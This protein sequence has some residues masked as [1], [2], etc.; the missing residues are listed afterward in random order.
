MQSEALRPGL[1][2][3]VR[4]RQYL[5]ER[6]TRPSPGDAQRVDLVCLDDDAQGRPLSVLWDLE[7]GAQVIQ[8]ES[9]GLGVVER[10]DE[11]RAFAAYLHALKWNC[12]TATDA[13]L[14]QAP[15]RAGI[16]LFNHQ[17]TPLQKALALPR[18]NLFIADDVGLG[19]TIEAGLVLQEL[20]LRQRAKT[21]LIVCP[22]SVVLQW[23]VEMERRFGIH[24]EIF[25][26]EF[27]ARR[28]QERG[29]AVNPWSTHSRFIVSYQTLRRPEHRDPLLQHLGERA[30]KSLL[31]LDEAHNAAPATSSKYAVDSRLTHMIRDLAPKFENRLFLSATPHNGHSNS[32]SALLEIL[33]PQRFTRGVKTGPKQ[34]EP[35][36]VRRLKSDLRELGEGSD[37]YPL[38]RV[39]K[40]EL[41]QRKD[42]VV[43]RVIEEGR[44]PVET[45]LG[46]GELV[47]L[48]LAEMLAK[49]TEL[50]KPKK[51]RGQLVFV[52]LQ[53]RLLS[54]V[55][56]F[57]RT[58]TL[59]AKSMGVGEGGE[60]VDAAEEEDEELYGQTDETQLALIDAEVIA[61]SK[62]L[63]ALHD[64]ARKLL[65]EML[66]LSEQH[67]S[68]PDGKVRTLLAWIRAN[69]LAGHEWND[70][71]LLVFTEFGDTKRY[72]L[73]QLV[74]ALE[75][76][77]GA[78]R[79]LQ[80]HGGM[81]DK[82]RD[83]V[84][85]AFNGD[86]SKYPVRILLATDSAREGINLQGAC[87]D[88]FHFDIPWNPARMEQRNGRIDRTLQPSPEVRCAYFVYPQ[89]AEDQVLEKVV[90]KV[91]RIQRELGS[92]G[93]VV[94]DRMDHALKSG[95][96]RDAHK[97]VD[98]AGEVTGRD[99]VR[100]ELE[101]QRTQEKLRKEIDHA[102]KTLNRSRRVMDFEE[103]LLRDALDVGCEMAGATKLTPKQ[104]GGRDAFV[105]PHLPD[106]WQPT[107][108]VLRPPADED[109]PF[110]EWRKRPPMPVVFHAPDRLDA[111]V[112][113][114]HL[115][116][117]FV[118]RM[119]SRFL[120][121]GFSAHDLS[122]VTAVRNSRDALVR[123]IAFGRLSLFGTGAS[124]LHDELVSVA[125]LWREG[126]GALKPFAEK[127]DRDAVERLEDILAEAPSLQ[128]IPEQ[129]QRKLREA[130]PQDFSALWPHVRD[131][132]QKMATRALAQLTERGRAESEALRK[133]LEGQRE[134]IKHELAARA[135]PMQIALP[136]DDFND[137]ERRQREDERQHMTGR[138]ADI[139][140][141]IRDEPALIQSGYEVKYTR[142]VPVGLI[143]LWP[144]TR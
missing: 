54:S 99:T 31:I 32:Y 104:V 115:Q 37:S 38:R 86:P 143:Y 24:F 100:Q 114:L 21:V 44:A 112:H 125:A 102:A 7:L 96:D 121:Q 49:Y 110:W 2:V 52:N 105:L 123:V 18:V 120:A 122:R 1:L 107:L 101:A 63:P 92:L 19:K 25:N 20:L 22:A 46:K 4:H 77:G 33:D 35:V 131:Q 17:L 124:R 108:D 89:R 34:V 130:A 137:D 87:A 133:I 79:I 13:S 111:P 140:K 12:V 144:T 61:A 139:D 106:S 14:F 43:S 50:Q 81:G 109:E 141:E 69:Q 8:P 45:D 41:E 40:V 117:P 78:D 73:E 85:L 23:R 51:G 42:R 126:K 119:L 16:R 97:R 91:E 5:V 3:R 136:L 59:H 57:H 88:L 82:K 132:S 95:I 47:E 10:L 116:H 58:L 71:R 60:A 53:T 70:R 64:E 67:R 135:K 68:A 128:A 74:A 62:S 80:L 26:R 27:V 83:Q 9:E 28:R 15:F 55:E 72:L 48:K 127:A 56:A 29:F 103:A 11:P 94:M 36:M 65:A 118:Q 75:D 93:A 98:R 90:E 113:H 76:E 39:L 66:R 129:A 30:R 138:L 84:Q 142:I 134:A 6:A